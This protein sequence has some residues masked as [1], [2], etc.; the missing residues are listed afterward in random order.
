MIYV[1]AVEGL[2]HSMSIQPNHDGVNSIYVYLCTVSY[3]NTRE[4]LQSKP[5]S[6]NIDVC[7]ITC[8]DINVK[9]NVQLQLSI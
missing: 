2:V 6:C 5:R 8:V 1:K 4:I 3:V 9:I 7:L